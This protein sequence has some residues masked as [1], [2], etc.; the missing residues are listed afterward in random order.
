[1]SSTATASFVVERPRPTMVGTRPSLMRKPWVAVGKQGRGTVLYRVESPGLRDVAA[2]P[3]AGRQPI[4]AAEGG[5]EG[6]SSATHPGYCSFR[7]PQRV[8]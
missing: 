3:A 2:L 5:R 4:C 1:M 8:E 6:R 7:C